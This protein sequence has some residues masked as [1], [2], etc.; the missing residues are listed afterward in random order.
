MVETLRDGPALKS[1][2]H[3]DRAEQDARGLDEM[4]DED[5]MAR[6]ANGDEAAFRRLAKRHAARTFA[7]AKRIL[8]NDADAGRPRRRP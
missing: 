8:M 7:L 3:R 1:R 4:C 5:L 2:G 6:V